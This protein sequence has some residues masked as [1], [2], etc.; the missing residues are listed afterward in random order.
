MGRLVPM[1]VVIG[2]CLLAVSPVVHS[3]CFPAIFNFGDS[4]S[5]TGNLAASFPGFTPAEYPP[6]GDTY[7]GKPSNRYSDGRLLID[8]IAQ[9]YGLPFVDPYL[10]SV[11]SEFNQGTNFAAAGST[12]LPVTYLSPFYLDIQL[13]EYR[14]FKTNVQNVFNPPDGSVPD[15][16]K[17]ARLPSP[18]DFST[19]LYTIAL[20]GN[21]FTYGYTKGKTVLEVRDYLP[22][23]IGNLTAAVKSLYDYGGRNFVVW[24]IEPH[25]CLP[26]TLTL[27]PHT[28]A[29]LDADGCL[30][31]YNDNAKWFNEQ[32]QIALADLR[33]N[34]TNVNLSIFNTYKLKSE[35]ISA[36][37]TTNGFNF[38]TKACCGVPNEFN[39]DLRVNC[40]LSNVIDGVN[41]TAVKCDD[42]NQYLVWDGVHNTDA[43]NKYLANQFFGGSYFDPPFPV[44]PEGCTLSAI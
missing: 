20:G 14:T 7:P 36:N 16:A 3:A 29:D 26:Y 30:I 44:T 34:L 24:D 15:E 9:A 37:T 41:L 40:G 19:G 5:D 23:V 18:E 38:T 11:N 6:Y 12:V 13:R 8:F 33:A 2:M 1:L 22:Q 27:I 43:A 39:F 42:P 31:A 21:D 28:A 25:G 10:Q 32:L 35:L 17:K 4:T